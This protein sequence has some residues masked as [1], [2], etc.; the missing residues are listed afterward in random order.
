MED[1]H[2]RAIS[3]HILR[4]H[5]YIPAGVAEGAP[6]PDS[7]LQSMGPI[8]RFASSSAGASAAGENGPT[9]V[10]ERYNQ[11]LHIG[12][13]APATSGTRSHRNSKQQQRNNE[14][15]LLSMEFVKKYIHYAKTRVKP[16]LTKEAADIL[17]ESYADLRNREDGAQD[18][19]RTM[20][21]TARTLETL[22]RLS[23][24]HA[25]SRLSDKVQ[26][27]DAEVAKE[28]LSFALYKEVKKADRNKKRRKVTRSNED[29]SDEDSDDNN[30]DGDD[31]DQAVRSTRQT[32]PQV[33][34]ATQALENVSLQAPPTSPLN[35]ECTAFAV[36]ASLPPLLTNP[37][38]KKPPPI[39]VQSSQGNHL[40]QLLDS[41]NSTQQSGQ[42]DR[43]A[44]FTE[45]LHQVRQAREG[46]TDFTTADILDGVNGLVPSSQAFS[47][48]E[49]KGY[50]RVMSDENK[51][52]YQEELQLVYFI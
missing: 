29:D 43:I 20:P 14:N 16:V 25:K 42:E 5:R 41:G 13:Q 28:I 30:G 27:E 12:I 39:L 21:I 32:Q 24:A 2:N 23:T 15:I 22:I 11:L 35:G 34:Q 44:M 45:R 49:M 46:A 7:L 31:G 10:Y 37:K 4:M 26:E 38:P 3:E 36:C 19:H 51:L 8:G 18:L 33:Q 40:S 48:E 52:W 17:A 6:I 50:L 9:P 1:E 47:D